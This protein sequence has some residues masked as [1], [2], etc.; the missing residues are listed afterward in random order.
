MAFDRNLY[1][2]PN[3]VETRWASPENFKAEKGK[4][5]Q[6]K[7]GRK[8]SPCFGLKAGETR[9]LAEETGVSGTIRLSLIHI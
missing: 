2:V 8:G 6:A 1:T 9:V 7:G 5:G 3:G 4:G